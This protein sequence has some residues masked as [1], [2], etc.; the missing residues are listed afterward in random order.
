LPS[1]PTFAYRHAGLLSIVAACLGCAEGVP[2]V[3][4]ED[5]V[6]LPQL[7]DDAGVRDPITPP[8]ETTPNPAPG[9]TAARPSPPPTPLAA[10][11]ARGPDAGALDAGP[12]A[13]A[14]G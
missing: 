13:D 4:G 6:I 9:A 11:P 1:T 3:A 7:P 5:V 14:G 8:V 2:I 12:A 10:A